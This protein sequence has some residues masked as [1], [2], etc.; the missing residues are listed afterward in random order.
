MNK[1]E[2]PP[3]K[4]ICNWC[5]IPAIIIW[6]HGHGQCSN[7]G[8]NIDECCKGESCGPKISDQKPENNLPQ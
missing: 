7:C 6:V 1:N 4:I 2:I 5:G 3:N 8:I